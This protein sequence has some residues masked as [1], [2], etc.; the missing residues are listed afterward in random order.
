MTIFFF[1]YGS[2]EVKIGWGKSTRIFFLLWQEAK[3]LFI[4]NLVHIIIS[5]FF[6]YICI[7]T[8][9]LHTILIMERDILCI[10]QTCIFTLFELLQGE[11]IFRVYCPAWQ[12]KVVGI[13]EIYL[14]IF[15]DFIVKFL[16]KISHSVHVTV[17]LSMTVYIEY[18][19]RPFYLV[20]IYKWCLS[21]PNVLMSTECNSHDL[22]NRSYISILLLKSIYAINDIISCFSRFRDIPFYIKNLKNALNGLVSIIIKDKGNTIDK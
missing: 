13:W 3:S 20:L 19:H 22:Q 18:Y 11:L 16:W 7:H 9:F 1:P 6:S 2:C 4:W 14:W 21:F 5:I 12:K 15:R 8:Q 10:P 17:I